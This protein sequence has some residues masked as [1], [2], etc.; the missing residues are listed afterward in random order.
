MIQDRQQVPSVL[1][2]CDQ[3]NI[4]VQSRNKFHHSAL[5]TATSDSLT[6]KT[7][8]F[9]LDLKFHQIPQACSKHSQVV[10]S[11]ISVSKKKNLTKSGMAYT[12]SCKTSSFGTNWGWH[13][14]SPHNFQ[15]ICNITES[16]SQLHEHQSRDYC[17]K[18]SG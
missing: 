7:T 14:F 15:S 13:T 6:F 8:P 5:V 1:I 3:K 18:T 2:S 11:A 10:Y 4:S 9:F 17:A 12:F 16:S